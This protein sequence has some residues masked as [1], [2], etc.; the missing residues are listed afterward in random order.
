MCDTRMPANIR[1]SFAN[2]WNSL[3]GLRAQP[4]DVGR[5]E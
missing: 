5:R 3:S 2:K 1:Y 4:D